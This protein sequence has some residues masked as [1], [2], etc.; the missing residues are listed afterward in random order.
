[1]FLIDSIKPNIEIITKLVFFT[2]LFRGG[3]SGKNVGILFFS[4]LRF[5]AIPNVMCAGS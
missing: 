3:E 5:R 2:R 4:E 1:M